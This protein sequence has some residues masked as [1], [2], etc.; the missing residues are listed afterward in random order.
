MASP[1]KRNAD[2]SGL[3]K[4]GRAAGKEF[5][6]K[7]SQMES[8]LKKQ[9]DQYMEENPDCDKEET[10]K[11][12]DC[13]LLFDKDMS[14]D[15]DSQELTQMYERLGKPKNPMEIR[16]EIEKFDKDKDGLINLYEFLNMS[17]GSEAS[18]FLKKLL[19]FKG[20]ELK[21]KEE[22]EREAALRDPAKRKTVLKSQAS[23]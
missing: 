3:Q 7:I 9:V 12:R 16:K 4:G 17:L 15:L 6:G 22:A 2:A 8:K 10:G 14:G 20:L 5:M 23:K 21:A 18:P 1:L 11:V 13:F 19:F